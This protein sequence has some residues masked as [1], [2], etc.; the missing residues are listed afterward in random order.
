[1][2]GND[3]PTPIAIIVYN[4]PVHTRQLLESLRKCAKF[5]TCP[6]YI[7]SD[8][9]K[10][11]SHK[12][13]VQAVRNIIHD[14]AEKYNAKIIEASKNLGLNTSILNGISRIFLE[15][16]RI[17]VLEDDLVLHPRTLEFMIQAL[18][19]YADEPRVGHVSGFNFPI[20]YIPQEEA[21]LLPLFNSWG[22][23]TWSRSWKDFEWSPDKAMKEMRKDA[24]LRRRLYP[25]Y[26]MFTYY[27][28]RNEM[29]WDLLWHWKLRSQNKLGVFPA[30]SLIWC[31]GFDDTS[32]HTGSVPKGYQAS[33]EQVM[34]SK[35]SEII[36]FPEEV[37]ANP[38]AIRALRSYLRSMY[39]HPIRSFYRRMRG[40]LKAKLNWQPSR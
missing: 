14:F 38:R 5:D 4:R 37:S 26:D 33:Y 35:L 23:A 13:S 31:S 29:V 22:W 36:C 30:T 10:D 32:T 24:G 9:A 40:M 27:Y 2:P 19:R 28:Q 34:A 12:D 1:M 25:Y 39:S 16:D 17:I 7:F 15:H 18:D 20:N 11:E 8:D 6:I 3:S 21:V